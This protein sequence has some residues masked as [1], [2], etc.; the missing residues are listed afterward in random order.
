VSCRGWL[1]LRGRFDVK[2]LAVVGVIF[3]GGAETQGDGGC[4]V[5]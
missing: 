1:V 2:V 4:V 3:E 5:L